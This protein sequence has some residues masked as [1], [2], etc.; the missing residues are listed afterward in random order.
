MNLDWRKRVVFTATLEPMSMNRFDCELFVI[1]ALRRPIDPCAQTETHFSFDNGSMQVLINRETGLIDRY[2]VH[3]KDLLAP[4]STQ[5]QAFRD[6][7][8][9]WKMDN[10]IF[11]QAIGSF[12]PLSAEEANRFRGYPDA[13]HANVLVTE[14]GPVRTKIQ[15]IFR[16]GNSFAVVTYTLPKQ[17][18]YV[19]IQLKLLV[20]DVNTMYKLAFTTTLSNPLFTGQTAYGTEPLRTDGQEVCFQKWCMLCDGENSL[21]VLNRANYGGS[22]ESGKL[23]IS[24][25]R[26]CV[27]SALPIPERP[28]TDDDR[29]HDHIDMGE[30]DFDFRL[31]PGTEHPD[32]D[33]EIFNQ[34]PYALSF[35]PSGDG[36]QRNTGVVLSNKKIL[37]SSYRKRG[38]SLLLRLYNGSDA[39][40]SA[41]LSLN[42]NTWTLDFAPFEAKAFCWQDGLLKEAPLSFL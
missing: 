23:N 34:P 29:Y 40:Q 32:A 36:E 28:T 35:F 8:D 17:D 38:S 37:L 14:N 24:L 11:D 21:T 18:C 4:G 39:A 19:D 27:H 10:E 42:G 3:G 2:R 20:N 22:A 31:V 13:K 15:A 16:H 12:A 41:D 7:E 5:V 1:P 25:L 26:T 30:H 9:P 6:H 33:A